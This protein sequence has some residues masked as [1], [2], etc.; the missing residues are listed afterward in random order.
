ME[1]LERI[2]YK[3]R[4]MVDY[5]GPAGF[6]AM[7]VACYKKDMGMIDMLLKYGANRGLVAANGDT[8]AHIA[9]RI[10]D[11]NMFEYFVPYMDDGIDMKNKAGET[12]QDICERT[13]DEVEAY[14]DI[15]TFLKW[16]QHDTE[17]TLVLKDELRTHRAALRARIIDLRKE[18]ILKRRA[19]LVR[20]FIK[21]ADDRKLGMQVYRHAGGADERRYYT[22]L[23]TPGPLDAEPWKEGDAEF[24]ASHKDDLMAGL[25]RAF[26]QEFVGRSAVTAQKL[27]SSTHPNFKIDERR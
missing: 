1:F 17:A 21:G 9:C 26:A 13:P 3:H 20:T 7:H 2:I 12:L 22:V 11:M 16:N 8:C 10:G 25:N 5:I 6:A 19:N 27:I 23:P 14:R 24:F 18:G 4:D 15:Y